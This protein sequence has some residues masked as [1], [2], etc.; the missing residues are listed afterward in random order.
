[1]NYSSRIPHNKNGN[2]SRLLECP[3]MFQT[4]NG[5]LLLHPHESLLILYSQ[6]EVENEHSLHGWI[7]SR[8]QPRPSLGLRTHRIRIFNC[9]ASDAI[10]SERWRML[11][12]P[13][14]PLPL[15]CCHCLHLPLSIVVV[16]VF[17]QNTVLVYYLALV[18]CLALPRTTPKPKIFSEILSALGAATESPVST[19]HHPP[20]YCNRLV[21]S[22]K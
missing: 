22:T 12:M 16:I 9:N 7:H 8:R 3:S 15:V 21:T 19:T 20:F 4:C 17:N 11:L 18:D 10:C 1:M 6:R 13:M 14:H 2:H 5:Q